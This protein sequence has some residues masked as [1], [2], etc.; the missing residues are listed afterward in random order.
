MA[1][2]INMQSEPQKVPVVEASGKL[3]LSNQGAP[4]ICGEYVILKPWQAVV[5]DRTG[6]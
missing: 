3:L 5:F 2:L 6:V 1:V 4:E